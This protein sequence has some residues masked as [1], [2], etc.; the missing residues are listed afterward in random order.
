M[1]KCFNQASNILLSDI[2]DI[3]DKTDK[4]IKSFSNLSIPLDPSDFYKDFGLLLHPK[5]GEPVSNL[6][7][8]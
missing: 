8:M 7:V 5:T 1:L 2:K 3:R 4:D 6:T